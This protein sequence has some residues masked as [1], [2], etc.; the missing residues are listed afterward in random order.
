MD[1][2]PETCETITKVYNICNQNPR[3]KEKETGA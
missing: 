2:A 1:R 3:K